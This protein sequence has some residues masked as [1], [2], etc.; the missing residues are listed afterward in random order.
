MNHFNFPDWTDFTRGLLPDLQHQRMQQHLEACEDCRLTVGLL[1]RLL[2]ACRGMQSAEPSETVM[3]RARG[4]FPAPVTL[5]NRLAR[6]TARL[7]YDSLLAPQPV[8]LRSG[9]EVA[10]QSAYQAGDY[11]L[12][13]RI[14]PEARGSRVALVG[15]LSLPAVPE[16]HVENVPVFVYAGK[17]IVAQTLSNRFG[18]FQM[19]YQQERAVRFRLRIHVDNGTRSILVPLKKVGNFKIVTNRRPSPTVHPD[20]RLRPACR[21]DE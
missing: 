11:A 7:V 2:T 17:R 9:V 12:D 13:L 15:Q 16:S 14:E 1:G 3:A 19:E 21:K 8:G 20:A 6:L 18:E 4:I 5:G 10:W